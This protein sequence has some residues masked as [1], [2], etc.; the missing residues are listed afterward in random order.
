MIQ[1][2]INS[3]QGSRI[4]PMP[5]TGNVRRGLL[6]LHTPPRDRAKLTLQTTTA[7]WQ[8]QRPGREA[9]SW[10]YSFCWPTSVLVNKILH[11]FG[12]VSPVL[13]LDGKLFRV[14][15]TCTAH[16]TT[17]HPS[18]QGPFSTAELQIM[19]SASYGVISVSSDQLLAVVMSTDSQTLTLS[20]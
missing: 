3:G 4:L 13:W 5:L 11:N 17:Q 18:W 1:I 12:R 19:W 9:G 15:N 10:L 16:V 2:W 8:K 7:V 14:I 20:D 6:G